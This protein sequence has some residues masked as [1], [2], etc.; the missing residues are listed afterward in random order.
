[1]KA[2]RKESS[3]SKLFLREAFGQLA[4]RKETWQNSKTEKSEKVPTLLVHCTS[5]V[6]CC[7]GILLG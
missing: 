5:K 4:F 7:V 2:K 6:S 3:C 1:M